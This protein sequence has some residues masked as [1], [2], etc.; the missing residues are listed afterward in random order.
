MV[1]NLSYE[2]VQT[3]WEEARFNCLRNVQAVLPNM[4][5]NIWW[6][7]WSSSCII[8]HFYTAVQ[9]YNDIKAVENVH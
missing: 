7:L 9:D 5:S 1:I 2:N 8:V 4:K 3:I 6:S